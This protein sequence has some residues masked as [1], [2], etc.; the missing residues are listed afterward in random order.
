MAYLIAFCSRPEGAGLVM[1]FLTSLWG[2]F[3]DPRSNLYG[4]AYPNGAKRALAFHLKVSQQTVGL[5]ET[6]RAQNVTLLI[7]ASCYRMVLCSGQM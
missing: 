1:P 3:G 7:C 5:G 4:E 6:Q 2:R